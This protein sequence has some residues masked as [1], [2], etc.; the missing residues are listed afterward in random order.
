MKCADQAL[1]L[2]VLS[3]LKRYSASSEEIVL[4]SS[5]KIQTPIEAQL[6]RHLLFQQS[7]TGYN[8]L[9]TLVIEHDT[10]ALK[11]V[12][13][14]IS[15]TFPQSSEEIMDAT[16]SSGM[17]PIHISCIRGFEDITNLLLQHNANISIRD[18]D[19]YSPL[20]YAAQEGHT[21]TVRALLTHPDINLS[22]T[23]STEVEDTALH[24][25]ARHGHLGVLSEILSSELTLHDVDQVNTLGQTALHIASASGNP[26][27]VRVLL[28]HGASVD[29]SDNNLRQPLHYAALSGSVEVCRFLVA[30]DALVDIPDINQLTPLALAAGSSSPDAHATLK[31]LVE[32]FI[33]SQQGSNENLLSTAHLPPQTPVFSD[34]FAESVDDV[35]SSRKASSSGVSITESD[36]LSQSFTDSYVTDAPKFSFA[37]PSQEELQQE[38]GNLLAIVDFT[39][40]SIFRYACLSGNIESV[41][42]LLSQG[43]DPMYFELPLDHD[44]LPKVSVYAL[45]AAVEN[46]RYEVVR[47]LVEHCDVDIHKT[48]YNG[49]TAA[50]FGAIGI[51]CKHHSFVSKPSPS[52]RPYYIKLKHNIYMK[53]RCPSAVCALRCLFFLYRRN[54]VFTTADNE[55]LTPLHMAAARGR[56]CTAAFFLSLGVDVNTTHKGQDPPLSFAAMTNQSKL[57]DCLFTWTSDIIVNHQNLSLDTP[58]HIAAHEGSF[59]SFRSLL[60]N[61]ADVGMVN[62]NGETVLHLAV[63]GNHSN[64]TDLILS[65]NLVSPMI[66][67]AS[68]VTPIH[69][70]AQN[71]SLSTIKML[72]H[73][74]KQQDSTLCELYKVS[75]DKGHTPLHYSVEARCYQVTKYLLEVGFSPNLGPSESA[76]ESNLVNIINQSDDLIVAARTPLH[77][78]CFYG[79]T[80]LIKL[81]IAHGGDIKTKCFGKLTCLHMAVA[82]NNGETLRTVLAEHGVT[83]DSVDDDSKLNKLLFKESAFKGLNLIEFG[84]ELK[85]HN[86][87]RMLSVI[88]KL[89]T[90]SNQT[91]SGRLEVPVTT[92]TSSY[93]DSA[94]DG[95]VSHSQNS[96]PMENLLRAILKSNE[97]LTSLA[98]SQLSTDDSNVLIGKWAGFG[99][100]SPL[101]ECGMGLSILH[102]ACVFPKSHF[103]IVRC[104]LNKKVHINA[105]TEYIIDAHQPLKTSLFLPVSPSAVALSISDSTTSDLSQ[106]EKG[107]YVVRRPTLHPTASTP[108]ELGSK[109]TQKSVCFR[110][111]LERVG[112]GETPLHVALRHLNEATVRT[113]LIHGADGSSDKSFECLFSWSPFLS[114]NIEILAFILGRDQATVAENFTS[115]VESLQTLRLSICKLLISFNIRP[116]LSDFYRA[117]VSGANMGLLEFVLHAVRSGANLEAFLVDNYMRT[118]YFACLGGNPDIIKFIFSKVPPH[119]S[120]LHSSYPCHVIIPRGFEPCLT[121]LLEYSTLNI[122]FDKQGLTCL[123]RAA[124]SRCTNVDGVIK[125][126]GNQ[127]DSSFFNVEA[128]MSKT[129]KESLAV[130]AFVAAISEY[131]VLSATLPLH[132]ALLCSNLSIAKELLRAGSA[133]SSGKNG[134]SPLHFACISGC[135][136]KWSSDGTAIGDD[137]K[138]TL[139]MVKLLISIDKEMV[140]HSIDNYGRTPLH[141]LLSSHSETI[142]LSFL[143]PDMTP[144]MFKHL[145]KRHRGN[146][147]SKTGHLIQVCELLITV[148]VD[149][150][151]LDKGR[152]SAFHYISSDVAK[153]LV[154]QLRL[155][156]VVLRIPSPLPSSRPS[157]RFERTPVPTSGGS[158]CV[159]L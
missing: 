53:A 20:H 104:L 137:F 55:G 36:S 56:I 114:Q 66:G 18:Y 33:A 111:C 96:D 102:L 43:V 141:Y 79:Y 147:N 29:S 100:S 68:S 128:R 94:C 135:K 106:K 24:L 60:A 91:S 126:L 151:R 153:E 59:D 69:L 13:S 35:T 71:C 3:C 25:A 47:Y 2:E 133:L 17:T 139:S 116:H 61:G 41:K 117:L 87:V 75:D 132:F 40:A 16:D 10:S 49:C 11:S 26:S 22:L 97:S 109:K 144:D 70:A 152:K 136:K 86:T 93:D 98:Y 82:S 1:V 88:A 124:M 44:E 5:D 140:K 155:R 34:S 89:Q 130:S 78:A 120:F 76:V 54:M 51:V 45:S 50:H 112:P 46:G 65:Q 138:N 77:T 134:V 32:S 92:T 67:D 115:S 113:L 131:V 145:S 85:C 48:D 21:T 12:L 8:I 42:F 129:E 57:I 23:D 73:N 62:A 118:G 122:T 121:Q 95:D 6:F 158:C 105:R 4:H 28:L 72:I 15:S 150:Y 84:L 143:D 9:H 108:R 148:G 157:S 119:Q 123:H 156:D 149:P 63:K 125:F 80:D 58:L 103:K 99:F 127:Y 30:A 107:R 74:L 52:E 7:M 31:Y 159:I 142:D 110:F 64:I 38:P 27:T 101:I 90:S 81:L 154:S 14:F 37:Q 83:E 146:F 19:G 39:G